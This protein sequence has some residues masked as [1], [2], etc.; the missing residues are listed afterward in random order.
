MT[1]ERRG[2]VYRETLTPRNRSFTVRAESESFFQRGL[3]T[4]LKGP[5]HI[6]FLLALLLATSTA[7]TIL[8]AWGVYTASHCLALAGSVVSGASLAAGILSPVMAVSIL[9]LS[10]ANLRQL[11]E[12]TRLCL[13]GGLGLLHGLVFASVPLAAGV[14][15]HHDLGLLSA[16]TAGLELGHLMMM[17]PV[18]FLLIWLQQQTWHKRG[19]QALSLA[20]ALMGA[21]WLVGW[22]L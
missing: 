13:L 10:L 2:E 12:K 6:V 9:L 21:Y 7:L 20:S 1:L 15:S 11:K 18:V 14:G 22:M 4:V 8:K 3:V 19:T 16:F 5:Y 17:V